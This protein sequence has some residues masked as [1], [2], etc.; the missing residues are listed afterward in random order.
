MQLRF[1]ARIALSSVLLFGPAALAVAEQGP[2]VTNSQQKVRVVGI[3]RDEANAITLPGIPVEVV[4]TGQTVYT[5]VDGRFVLDLNPGAHQVKVVMEG[6]EERLVSLELSPGQRN[7]TADVGLRMTAFAETV[8]V[9]GVAPLDAIT[10]TQEAQLIERRQA[11]VISDNLGSQEMKANADSDAAAAMSRV[12]GLSV[13]DNQYVFVRGLGERYSNTTLAGAVIPT[14][15]PDKKVVPLDMFPAGLLDSVQVSKSYSPDRSAEFAGGLVQIVPL[16]LPTQPVVDFS[17]GLSVFST[18]TGKSVPFSPLD[19]NDLFGYNRGARALPASIPDSKIVRRG[20]YTPSIGYSPEEIAAF[21]RAF[22]NSSWRPVASDGAPGQNWGAVFGNRFGKLGVV[23]SVTHSYKEQFVDEDRRFFRIAD[24][25]RLEAVSDYSLQTGTQKAQLGVVANLSYQFAPSHRVSFENFYSHSGR[26]EGRYFEGPNTENSR[27]YRNYRLQFIEEGLMSNAVSGE[28]FFQSWNN[29]RID[30]R[31]NVARAQRSEPDLRETLYEATLSTTTL[32]PTSAFTLA[33]ESQSGFRMFN[34]LDDDTIDAAANWSIFSTAGGRPTQFK[35]G[36]AYVERTRDFQSRRFRYVPVVLNKTDPPAVQFD[37]Q[38]PP[39][40]LY[41]SSNIGTAFNFLETTRPV[42][43]YNGDQTTIAG[44]GMIDI[45]LGANTRLIT[46]ARV[47]NFDQTVNTFDPFGLFVRTVSSEIS[48]TDVFPAVNLVQGLGNNSNLRLSYSATVN[49]P[50]FRELAPFEFTDV[51]GNRS[52]RGN[53]DLDRA[54]IQNFDARWEM[55]PGGRN[56]LAASTFFKYFDQPIE[57]VVIAGAQPIVT[58]QNADRA[59][60]FG[61]ELEA[62]QRVGRNVFL[63]ANYTFV[64]STI[65]LSPEQR[66]VQT[67]S[68][69][70]LAGQSKNLFNLTGEFTHRGF[71][72]RALVNYFGDRISDVGANQAPD[73]IEEGRGS[74]DLVVGQRIGRL[75]VRFSADNVTD[76]EYLFTQGA[77]TQRVFKLGRTFSLSVG[78]SVF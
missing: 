50:E 76:G 25:D 32:L 78:L 44:Y 36:A 60:N 70:A 48:N 51:V 72:A 33:D 10:S 20:I 56:V 69:R 65:T 73:V 52:V 31:V 17:Y 77:E 64:D 75:N 39:E 40:E 37:A 6:Y 57:R 41:T 55:F 8:T 74:V 16:K 22:D 12:T 67:S 14:T 58:F 9:T 7:V 38:L 62:G 13:V 63:S 28:H 59:R 49:R 71:T 21:G 29:S 30:W 2:Q 43:A 35:F 3:V 24:D 11:Q 1:P 34:D 46:G 5:D 27:Y 54:L 15:E 47:E 26:D 19:G 53:T 4:G 23:G 68:E 42:D 18:A 61:I 45:T 66:T